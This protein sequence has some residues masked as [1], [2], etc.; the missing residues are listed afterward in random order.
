MNDAFMHFLW[1]NVRSFIV[2]SWAAG[3]E[4]VVVGS[5]FSTRAELMQF[6]ST[7]PDTPDDIIVILLRA[8]RQQRDERRLNRA[9]PTSAEWR[10]IADKHHPE[11]TTLEDAQG[12][13]TFLKI[14]S[15]E[16]TLEETLS[17]ITT[18]LPSV[19]RTAG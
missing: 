15:S 13:Y 3:F 9:K 10:D 14:D 11:D 1:A 8:D 19:C 6:L 17:Q 16:Q 5:F 2:H 7:L 4:T 18:L 12:A